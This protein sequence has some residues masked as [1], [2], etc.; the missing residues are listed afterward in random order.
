MKLNILHIL[1]ILSILLVS[2]D[3]TSYETGEG[4]L[5]Y[6]RADYVDMKIEQGRVVSIQT[7]D[8]ANLVVPASLTYSEKKDT[9]VR[10]LLYYKQGNDGQPIQLMGQKNVSWLIPLMWKGQENA[11]TD[12]LTLTAVWL[13]RNKRYLNMQLGIKVGSSEAEA[14]QSVVLRCDSVSTYNKGAMWLTL[15]HDQGGMPEYYTREILLS[16]PANL[17]PDTIYFSTNTYSGK[18]TRR[19]IK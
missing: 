16:V 7:D 11:Q 13:S 18:T 8:D 10:C 9:L 14:S 19:L 6:M 5:S 4:D 15:C 3:F 12:P 2:C 17:L 1:F